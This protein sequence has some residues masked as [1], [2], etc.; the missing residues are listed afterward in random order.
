MART[1]EQPKAEKLQRENDAL[2]RRVN[3]QEIALREIRRLLDKLSPDRR[4]RRYDD[5][6]EA[7]KRWRDD[8]TRKA[9]SR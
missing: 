8:Q 5:P 6:D 7:L 2:K 9:S 3:E 1:A 4:G